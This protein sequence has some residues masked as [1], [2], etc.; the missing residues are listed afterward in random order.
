MNKYRPLFD[1]PQL[2]VSYRTKWGILNNGP[3]EKWSRTSEINYYITFKAR[4]SYE[5]GFLKLA[6][7]T[8]SSSLLNV[9]RSFIISFL[10]FKIV[11]IDL[12][13][14]PYEPAR[15]KKQ[16]SIIEKSAR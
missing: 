11:F 3:R 5:R 15:E 8:L 13:N 16:I 7:A 1:K 14:G 2:A 10:A 12:P 9:N 6:T 4:H